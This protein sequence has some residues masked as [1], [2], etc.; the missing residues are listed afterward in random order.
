MS[1]DETIDM[2][3]QVG[4]E[5]VFSTV[6]A[7]RGE[8]ETFDL[9]PTFISLGLPLS[10]FKPEFR[11]SE[12]TK[13]FDA[14]IGGGTGFPGVVWFFTGEDYVRYDLRNQK[15]TGPA[16]IA[17]NWGSGHWPPMFAS[18]VDA[19]ISFTNEPEFVWFFKGPTYIRYHLA[20]DQLDGPA[21]IAGNWNGFPESFAEGV[22]R[23]SKEAVPSRGWVVLQRF[24]LHTLQ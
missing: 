5:Q 10:A 17:G 19:V 1:S 21:P 2:G 20:T 4:Q 9:K 22:A 8:V 24:G 12:N 15:L 18:G 14:S 23:L 16:T 11:G 13:T 6:S 3:G 7:Q